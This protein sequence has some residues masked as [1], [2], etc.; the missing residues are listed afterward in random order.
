MNNG[1][2]PAMT[3]GIGNFQGL[4]KREYFAAIA[5][6]GMLACADEWYDNEYCARYALKQADCLL[7]ELEKSK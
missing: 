2:L 6:Q 5:M 4:S 7:A 1:D 3:V